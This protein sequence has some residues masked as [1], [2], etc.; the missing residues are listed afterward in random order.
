MN[1]L[2]SLAVPVIAAPMAGGP[3]TPALALAVEKAGGLGFLAAGTISA[4]ELTA[5]LND[6]AG[7]R[8]AVNLF[9]RQKPLPSLAPVRRF[10]EDAGLAVDALPDVDYTNGW[11]AKFAA[12]LQAPTPPVAVSSTFGPFSRE[13]IAQLHGAGIEAWVTVTNPGDAAEAQRLGADVLVVQGPD[14]GGHRGTWTVEET[15]DDRP[16]LNLLHDLDTSVPVVAAGG[17]DG[18]NLSEILRHC[19]AVSIGSAFLLAEEAGTSEFNRQL[20]RTGGISVSTRGFSGRVARG[21]ETEFTR[22]REMPAIYPYVNALL[23]P[24]RSDPDYAYCL[25]GVRWDDQTRTAADIVDRLA[26]YL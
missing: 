17:I 18:S 11:E 23:K 24:L 15:P 20:L 3:S 10:I 26:S 7:H 25:V 4:E 13:E 14:A 19:D 6:V 2:S 8:Y 16:L 9:A 22:A 1:V 12:V 5:Q 21:L